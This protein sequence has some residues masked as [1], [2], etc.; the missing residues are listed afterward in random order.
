MAERLILQ[1]FFRFVELTSDTAFVI[2]PGSM[3]AK[4]ASIRVR[5]GFE[6]SSENVDRSDKQA[7]RETN[8]ARAGLLRNIQ[9]AQIPIKG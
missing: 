8:G 9:A 5:R 3:D 7:S 6:P 4:L 1:A 2:C